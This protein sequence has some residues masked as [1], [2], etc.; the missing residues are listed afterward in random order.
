MKKD[1]KCTYI[2]ITMNSL[3][4]G[5]T[6][7]HKEKEKRRVTVEF[8]QEVFD[9]IMEYQKENYLPTMTAAIIQ[10]V[11]KALGEDK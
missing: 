3:Q 5:V 2:P 4:K 8:P 1:L 11:I 6:K 7:M 10:L 9:K